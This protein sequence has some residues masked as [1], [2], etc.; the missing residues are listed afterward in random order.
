MA[1][2]SLTALLNKK[3]LIQIWEEVS[4]KTS[5]SLQ[6]P[7][8]TELKKLP[9]N[10]FTVMPPFASNTY[11][12]SFAACL[13]HDMEGLGI[14]LRAGN[15]ID[16]SLMIKAPHKYIH[17]VPCPSSNLVAHLYCHAQS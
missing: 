3:N 14:V 2:F 5:R 17:T 6:V 13:K 9:I 8:V 16:N 1:S 12:F 11:F 15:C 4:S 7:V 10:Y